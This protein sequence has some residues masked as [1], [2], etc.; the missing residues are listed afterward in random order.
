MNARKLPSGSWRARLFLGEDENGKKHYKSFT[1]ATKREAER[2]ALNYAEERAT[3]DRITFK[4]AL[5]RYIES[6]SNVLS[7]S[8][9][10][11]YRQMEKYYD[12]IKDMDVSEIDQNTV[13]GFINEFAGKHSPKTVRNAYS[14][15]CAVIRLQI[16]DASFRVTMPQK[17]ILQYY[18]PKDEELQSLLSYTKTANYDLYVAIL[19]ASIG[20][21]RRS[22][23]CGLYAD[24]IQGNTVHVHQTMVKNQNYK[25]V[26]KS[27]AKNSTSDR[28]VEYPDKVIKE[29]PVSGKICNLN[30]D[31]IT[32]DFGRTIKKLGLPHFRFH[33]LRHYAATIMHAM[34]VPEAYIMERGGWKTNTVLNQVYRGTRSDFS[35]KYSDQA[36]GYFENHLL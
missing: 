34:G 14:L 6:K 30:P 18:I 2:L 29:L 19:L 20:T 8:T 21:L 28:Y 15:L 24:D 16:P 1:A 31:M 3:P 36:N 27:V 4:D 35:K 9:L 11:G 22:E 33:D 13:V 12:P 26:L 7:P 10:R 25:W 17:E 23:V 32:H 5:T